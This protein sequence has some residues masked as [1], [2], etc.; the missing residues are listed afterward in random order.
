[1]NKKGF[2][3][4]GCSVTKF[5]KNPARTPRFS[6]FNSH[7]RTALDYTTRNVGYVVLFVI[8]TS[9]RLVPLNHRFK[10]VHFINEQLLLY[11]LRKVDINS[12]KL[13]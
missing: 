6:I 13:R 10:K 9:L 3:P 4:Q 5:I 1:M 2:F 8:G 7:A 12:R 11:S